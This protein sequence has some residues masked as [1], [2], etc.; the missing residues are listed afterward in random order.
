MIGKRIRDI[1][2]QRKMT[3]EVLALRIGISKSSISEWEACKRV[4][5]IETLHKLADALEIT[6]D[7]LLKSDTTPND[8]RT[9]PNDQTRTGGR[10]MIT[11]NDLLTIVDA[12]QLRVIVPVSPRLKARITVNTRQTAELDDI[13]ARGP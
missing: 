10:I 8:Q 5:R 12:R 1:R 3:Q 9:T 6:I 2:I 13:I 7:M 4:P 11:L